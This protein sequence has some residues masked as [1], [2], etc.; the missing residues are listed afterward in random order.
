MGYPFAGDGLD[1]RYCAIKQS[2]SG[3]PAG[4]NAP[5]LFKFKE[6]QNVLAAYSEV[7]SKCVDRS[8][9]EEDLPPPFHMISR[10]MKRRHWHSY[11]THMT[12][13]NGDAN[14]VSTRYD[15]LLPDSSQKPRR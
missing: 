7:H 15:A 8:S 3:T 11:S 14:K 10:N 2:V 13:T 1:V 4:A 12:Q 5:Y 9:Q 6:L